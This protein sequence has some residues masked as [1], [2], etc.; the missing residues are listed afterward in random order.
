[1]RS[2]LPARLRRRPADHWDHPSQVAERSRNGK[3]TPEAER[4]VHEAPIGGTGRR[5][6]GRRDDAGAPDLTASQS[7]VPAEAPQFLP[8]PAAAPA[9]RSPWEAIGEA[10]SSL[11]PAARS[12]VDEA[13]AGGPARPAGERPYGQQ[14]R[15][16]WEDAYRRVVAREWAAPQVEFHPAPFTAPDTVP[17]NAVRAH[18]PVPPPPGACVTVPALPRRRPAPAARVTAR[19]AATPAAAPSRAE[20]FIADMRIRGG[21]P[22]FRQTARA[23]GWCGLDG[24]AS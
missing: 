17:M 4:R 24:E 2:L 22:L 10:Y 15:A 8:A 7:R 3:F 21:L 12:L 20:L 18:A 11:A 1:M 9:A 5:N 19:S 14:P 23:V 16:S 6:A 13:L